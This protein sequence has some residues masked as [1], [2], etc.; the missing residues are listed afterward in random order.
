MEALSLMCNDCALACGTSDCTET[1]H[2]CSST[3]PLGQ[4]FAVHWISSL[5]HLCGHDLVIDQCKRA[6]AIK[7]SSSHTKA[8]LVG[9]RHPGVW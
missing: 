1:L 8:E 3:S 9:Q 4:A 6:R 2:L 5:E 7:S